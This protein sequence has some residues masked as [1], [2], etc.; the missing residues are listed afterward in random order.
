MFC[1]AIE[2]ETSSY[3][4]VDIEE[5]AADARVGPHD[6]KAVFGA[7][8]DSGGLEIKSLG[9][10]VD[11]DVFKG[12]ADSPGEGQAPF[13]L[14]N[15]GV[16]VDD[17]DQVTMGI[18]DQP[19]A[20]GFQHGAFVGF[21]EFYNIAEL[22]SSFGKTVRMDFLW[23]MRSFRIDIYFGNIFPELVGFVAREV[24]PEDGSLPQFLVVW[25]LLVSHEFRDVR[26]IP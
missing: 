25:F 6:F 26:N 23:E 13:D 7:N 18:R 24:F 3:G 21:E 16:V 4:S 9:D 15:L 12:K 22:S 14:V 10:G 17:S 5:W 11:A 19:Q 2:G 1:W 20:C 8:T